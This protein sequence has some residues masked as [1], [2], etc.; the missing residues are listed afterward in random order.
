MI[1]RKPYAFLIKNF[2]KIHVGLILLCAY[3][4]YKHLQ[5]YNFVKEYVEL[6]S[7]SAFL[8]PI[9]KYTNLS[10][11]LCIILV[12]AITILL[13]ITLKRK[14]KPWKLYLVVLGEY[15]LMLFVFGM[16]S[17]FFHTYSDTSAVVQILAIRDLLLIASVPQYAVFV[18]LLLRITGLDLNKFSFQT[19]KEFLELDS[20][21]RE[22]V[23]VSF[24]IDKHTIIRNYRKLKR[25]LGYFYLEHKKILN[26][27]IVV[28]FVIA[29]GY[30]YYY[31]GI[32]HKSYKEGDILQASGWQIRI[33][34]AYLSDKDFKGEI[35]DK[36]NY[37]ILDLTVKNNAGKRTMDTSRFH[38]MNRNYDIL[39]NNT[40]DNDF[41]DLGTPYSKREFQAGGVYNFLLIFKADEKLDVNKFNLY[42]QE[43]NQS[44]TYLRKIKL[45][46][47]DLR[48]IT[49]YPDIPL[50]KDQKI[51]VEGEQKEF[52][53]ENMEIGEGFWYRRYKCTNGECTYVN[54]PI[55]ENGV[56]RILKI[57]FSST[58]F[59]GEEFVDFC[60][61]Y[62]KIK[63]KDS[64]NKIKTIDVKN[65]LRE[66]ALNSSLYLKV[67]LE[68]M[69]SSEIKLELTVRNHR[70]TFK[71]R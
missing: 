57:D 7:Y 28:V 67:P 22:E 4:F 43:Y 66:D 10:S 25:N 52:S 59:T 6:E 30:T 61:D 13:L 70:Y 37:I 38:L 69:S 12:I 50:G 8:E 60:E 63:Y 68:V 54:D 19:D 64:A 55:I 14:Q 1:L 71:L 42:Y 39:S 53:L 15:L 2:R 21:D 26:S 33:N 45:K 18:I 32:L 24:E 65:A 29:I 44:D 9:D 41:K 46:L 5:T 27:L 48:T 40:Y 51:K 11:Y 17:N 3:I 31:F 34:K 20:S 16:T 49:G 47:E 58:D 56:N 62:G 35:I 36:D 23:E